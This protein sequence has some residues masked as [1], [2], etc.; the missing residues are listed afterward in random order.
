MDY[1]PESYLWK[2]GY[3]QMEQHINKNNYNNNIYLFYT[4]IHV[5]NNTQL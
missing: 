4:F 5:H 1:T 2:K 3:Q